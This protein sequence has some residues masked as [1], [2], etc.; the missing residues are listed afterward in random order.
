MR[1]FLFA[2]ND[3]RGRL[4]QLDSISDDLTKASLERMLVPKIFFVAALSSCLSYIGRRLAG[5]LSV[6]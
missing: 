5:A 1:G 2:D 6:K 3:E 4:A